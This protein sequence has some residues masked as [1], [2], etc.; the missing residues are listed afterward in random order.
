MNMKISNLQ[1]ILFPVISLFFI[2]SCGPRSGTEDRSR[3]ENIKF[4]QYL[5]EGK[6]LY[7]KHC[8]NCHQEDGTGLV[9]LY[10]PIK[11]SDYLIENVEKTICIMKNGQ[12]GEIVVNGITYNQPMP[13]NPRLTN[14]EIAEIAT[15]V[16]TRWGHQ[17]RW[18]THE[19]VRK[20]LDSC[21]KD[22]KVNL[23]E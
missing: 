19:E 3:E 10:P 6:R 20:I 1:V 4:N 8:S 17:E 23:S 12:S 16:F 14:L 2:F 7:L 11:D 15:Y 21:E 22:N 9:R 5:I 18:F 13:A